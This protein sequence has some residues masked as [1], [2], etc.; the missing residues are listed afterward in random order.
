[1]TIASSGSVSLSQINTEIGVASTNSINMNGEYVR[2]IAQKP[3][4]IV[5]LDD[6]RGKKYANMTSGFFSSGNPF[7]VAYLGFLNGVTYFLANKGSI[8]NDKSLNGYN[9]R[10]I[11]VGG[12]VYTGDTQSLSINVDGLTA[13]EDLWTS[14][15]LTSSTGTKTYYR[16]DF[17]N[18]G[19]NTD[20]NITYWSTDIGI[21]P[22]TELDYWY[23]HFGDGTQ[24]D[25]IF[26]LP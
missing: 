22:S 11:F 8:S 21:R 18:F 15:T 3:S 23:T 13:P 6:C 25:V 26:T 2:K 20:T 14:V 5:T 17:T 24:I 19:T 16:A 12:S 7:N 10:G 4:G 1:M 9:L